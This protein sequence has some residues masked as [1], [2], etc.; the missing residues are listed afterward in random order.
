M[1]ALVAGI[2]VLFAAA[3]QAKAWMAATSAAMTPER[4]FSVIAIRSG[5]IDGLRLRCQ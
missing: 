3:K 2:H 4:W 5:F 1:P